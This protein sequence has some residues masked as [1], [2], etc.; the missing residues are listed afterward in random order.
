MRRRPGTL[1]GGL[2]GARCGLSAVTSREA[3]SP[4]SPP[5]P[6]GSPVPLK[7]EEQAPGTGP[8]SPPAQTALKKY[9]C[10][11]F[12]AEAS[13]SS[14]NQS[15]YDGF[16]PENEILSV[17]AMEQS[18]IRPVH[19]AQEAP[20][21]LSELLSFTLSAGVSAPA[22]LGGVAKG[23]AERAGRKPRT[24]RLPPRGRA[25]PPVS[26]P[27]GSQR[28]SRNKRGRAEL[29]SPQ[30]GATVP[31]PVIDGTAPGIEP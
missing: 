14:Q 25:L 28:R 6:A 5:A 13:V 22:R 15:F 18:E 20:G 30:S 24:L 21:G 12:R 17:Q 31:G 4:G 10:Q 26:G 7:S 2:W 11:M 1:R 27:C 8:D 9:S 23:N 3:S 19:V 16:S 29:S